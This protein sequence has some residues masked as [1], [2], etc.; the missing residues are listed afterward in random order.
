MAKSYKEKL[1]DP[2][3]QKKRLKILDR[4]NFTCQLCNDTETTLHVHHY[5]YNKNYNPW[6]V[7]DNCLV[8]YCSDCHAFIEIVKER[9][10]PYSI[11]KIIK[12]RTANDIMVFSLICFND[13]GTKECTMYKKVKDEYFYLVTMSPGF[14]SNVQKLLK[15]V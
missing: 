5:N 6:D 2:R 15:N 14:I 7:E 11:L 9:I 10:D 12:S 8:T 1:L 13:E 3:W 4:D